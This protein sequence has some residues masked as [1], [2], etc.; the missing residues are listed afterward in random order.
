MQFRESGGLTLVGIIVGGCLLDGIVR[1]VNICE[2]KTLLSRNRIEKWITHMYLQCSP[3]CNV[4]LRDE[5]RL[6]GRAKHVADYTRQNDAREDVFE[7]ER[8]E[9]YGCDQHVDSN[10]EFLSSD[11]IRIIHIALNLR[12]I[13]SIL[14]AG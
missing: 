12:R 6:L 3:L 7:R 4:Y 13:V 2:A 9:T 8:S 1:D 14:I 11:E 10:I 5:Q